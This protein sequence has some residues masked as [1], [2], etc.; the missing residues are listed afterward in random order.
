MLT[1]PKHFSSSFLKWP[2]LTLGL[3]FFS[4]LPV[5]AKMEPAPVDVEPHLQGIAN[6]AQS[7]PVVT[8]P[9]GWFLMGTNRED[10]DRHTFEKNYDNTE[11][12]ERRIWID[13]YQLDLYEVSLGEIL[14]FLLD[15]GRPVSSELRALIWHLI[16]IHYIPDQALAPWPALYVTWEEANAFC[17]K[18][19]KRLPSEAEWEKLPEERRDTSFLGEHKTPHRTLL[20]L[21]LTTCMKFLWSLMW[22]VFR[23]AKA[24]GGFITWQAIYLNGSMIGLAQTTIPSCRNV[25]RQDPNPGAINPFE[26]DHGRASRSCFAV[27]PAEELFPK[28]A[29]RISASAAPARSSNKLVLEVFFKAKKNHLHI[30]IREEG[31]D[32]LSKQDTSAPINGCLG[33]E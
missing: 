3:C 33:Y 26:A 19:E 27:P 20:F 24:N 11:F 8:I 31:K 2:M 18:Q 9:A 13:A 21:A 5:W 23:K 4:A 28:N 32:F 1:F 22:I 14:R 17:L 29:P 30:N 16:S 7:S 25:I 12:P 10:G 15:T 6:F